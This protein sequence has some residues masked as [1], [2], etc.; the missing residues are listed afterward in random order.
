MFDYRLPVY[1]PQDNFLFEI[2]PN[3]VFSGGF[4]ERING[5]HSM[6]ITT[7]VVLEKEQRILIQDKTEKWREFVISGTDRAHQN[8]ERPFGTYNAVWSLQHDFK[9][10]NSGDFVQDGDLTYPIG[11]IL[12]TVLS[13]T[14]RWKR[15]TISVVKRSYVEII[16]KNGWEALTLLCNE[17]GV[18]VDAQIDVDT[19]GVVSRKVCLYDRMG[20]NSVTRRFDYSRDLISMSRKVDEMPV[21]CRVR[22]YGKTMTTVSGYKVKVTVEDE[23]GVD[24]IQD[25]EMVPILRLSDG[26]GGYEYPTTNIENSSIEDPEEL[27]EWA[28]SV[29]TDYTRPKVTYSATVSQ[30]YAAGMDVHGVELGDVVHCVDRGFSDEGIRIESRVIQI[31]TD[32]FDPTN[33]KLTLGDLTTSYVL[34]ISGAIGQINDRVTSV[35]DAISSTADYLDNLIDHI[36][37]EINATGGYFYII[38]GQGVRTYDKAVSDP[39]VGAE[40]SAV[41]EIKGGTIRIANSKSATGAWEWKTVF[42]SGHIAAEVVTAAQITTGYIGS[43]GGTYINLD[44]DTVNLGNED[45]AHVVL[46]DSGFKLYDGNKNPYLRII[47]LTTAGFMVKEDIP[48]DGTTNVFTTKFAVVDGSIVYPN[49]VLSFR[50]WRGTGYLY[51]TRIRGEEAIESVSGKTLTLKQSALTDYYDGTTQTAYQITVSYKTT[52]VVAQI[53]S[54][55]T[56]TNAS[57]TSTSGNGGLSFTVGH[58]N[59]A[60]KYLSAAFGESTSSQSEIQFVIGK[61]NTIDSNNKYAFVVG[62]GTGTTTALRS[63]ALTLT[64]EGLLTLAGGIS[65]QE[66]SLQ[67]PVSIT[68]GG[69]GQSALTSITDSSTLILTSPS[70]ITINSITFKAWG[71]VAMLFVSYKITRSLSFDDGY[72]LTNPDY[73]TVCTLA[74]AYRPT[75]TVKAIGTESY[76]HYEISTGGVLQLRS[77]KTTYSQRSRTSFSGSVAFTYLLSKAVS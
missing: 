10:F 59:Y 25:D 5:E 7:S 61:Y 13:G 3:D 54:F 31:D 39:S 35:S 70:D 55:G 30:F 42:T 38:P 27:V 68:N 32:L 12:D 16:Q 52:D 29:M 26:S 47:D 74:S 58:D 76:S 66:I 72:W 14:A 60:S 40:A 1:S 24:Y 6:T 11:T 37:E 17:F 22:P 65:A 23:L 9:L 21:A 28:R 45:S 53:F 19:Q 43:T 50:K 48:C 49:L 20:N 8:G 34:S 56:R 67:N 62:N 63:N 64:W 2:S 75:L 69:T 36:N 4:R 18:E 33:T 77:L 41:V 73:F 51:Y 71:L 46:D 15:G 57:S 44:D